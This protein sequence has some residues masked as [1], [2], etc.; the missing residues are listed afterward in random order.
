M[1]KRLG[2]VQKEKVLENKGEILRYIVLERRVR[3]Y[4]YL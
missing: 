3:S 2:I 4:R 1:M